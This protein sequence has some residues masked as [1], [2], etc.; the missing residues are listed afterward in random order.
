MSFD[1]I[2]AVSKCAANEQAGRELRDH[3]QNTASIQGRI[4]EGPPELPRAAAD[5]L[6]QVSQHIAPRLEDG[7]IS[8]KSRLRLLWAA[9]RGAREFG[10]PDAVVAEFVRLANRTGFTR[11]L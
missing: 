1:P 7:S 8:E 2:R 4:A 10:A 5:L 3:P 6:S 11:A 9:A